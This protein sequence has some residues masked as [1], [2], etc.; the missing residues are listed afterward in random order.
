MMMK[1]LCVLV[2]PM[3]WGLGHASR[4]VPVV[5]A[6]LGAG[7]RV[8]V[9]VSGPGAELI[10]EEFGMAGSPETA[11]QN[12]VAGQPAGDSSSGRYA[13][14]GKTVCDGNDPLMVNCGK[15]GDVTCGDRL[16]IIPFPGFS[17]SYSPKFLFLSLM[18]RAPA[19]LRHISREKRALKGLVERFRPDLIV[20]DNRYGLVHP[21]VTSVI[22]THQLRPA[23]PLLLRP[24]EGLVSAVIRRWVRAFDEC[25]IP[26]CA[27]DPAAGRL[28]HGHE[29]LPAVF[30]TGWL[31]RFSPGS[32]CFPESSGTRGYFVDKSSGRGE[33]SASVHSYETSGSHSKV[34]PAAATSAPFR[35]RVMVILSGPEP[36]RK[37]LEDMV[38]A[39]MS[40]SPGRALLVR[41]TPGSFPEREIRGNLEIVSFMDSGGLRKAM[42]ESEILVCRSGYSSVMDLLVL[43]R[44]AVLVPTPGQTEQEHLG[45]WLDSR[46]WF[47]VVRQQD[48]DLRKL[49]ERPEGGLAEGIAEG[50]AG[51]TEKGFWD[52]QMDGH[53]SR[54]AGKD[55]LAERVAAALRK[56]PVSRRRVKS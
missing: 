30:F 5:R 31:S 39:R 25:W 34:S 41:G 35:Y 17:V 26:D 51:G 56:A 43:G 38:T 27:D 13:G 32:G 49:M 37:M 28:T 8:V 46:G 24:L 45:K 2:C 33:P 53:R 12:G 20:S 9:G 6:F 7:C 55:R 21:R 40:R 16:Q 23:M 11:G 52:C 4:C 15:P 47:R 44:R 19:F 48:F 3:D 22:I 14:S 36:H 50:V 18:L 29:K 10:R 54:I 42:G 1:K